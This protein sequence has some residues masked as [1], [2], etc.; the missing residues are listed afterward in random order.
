MKTT[1]CQTHFE[2]FS[3]LMDGELTGDESSA[4]ETHLQNCPACREEFN[5]LKTSLEMVESN[6]PRLALEERVWREIETEI[7]ADLGF[8]PAPVASRPPFFSRALRWATFSAAAG[9]GLYMVLAPSLPLSPADQ[10]LMRQIDS[11]IESHE[12]SMPSQGS[13]DD[14]VWDVNPFRPSLEPDANPFAV[15]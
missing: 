13:F 15:E 14:P 7:S 1:E 2:S 8:K 12:R 10:E 4:V 6:L 5:S 11:L 9:L 3:A